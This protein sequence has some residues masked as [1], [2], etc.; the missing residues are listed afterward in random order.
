[1]R[2]VRCLLALTLSWLVGSCGGEVARSTS[3]P[4]KI[5][6]TTAA[7]SS[8]LREGTDSA[9]QSFGVGMTGLPISWQA[10]ADVTWLRLTPASG[11]A[12]STVSVT[13]KSAGLAAGNHIGVIT[14]TPTDGSTTSETVTVLLS[15]VA[16]SVI[17]INPTALTFTAVANQPAVVTQTVLVTHSRAGDVAWSVTPSAS[18]LMATPTS[19]IGDAAVSVG[20]DARTLAAGT[21]RE[22]LTLSSPTS[23]N[24]PISIPITL[25][26]SQPTAVIQVSASPSNGGTVTGA[27]TFAIGSTASLVATPGAGFVF[28]NW[29]EG[30]TVVG[31]S[32]TYSFAVTA[33]RS[34]VANFAPVQSSVFTVSVSSNPTVGGSTTGAGQYSSGITAT[35]RA[36]PTS[37]YSFV[38]WTENG[39]IVSS[40]AIYNFTVNGNRALV[41]NF[42][43]SSPST[44][45]VTTASSPAAGGTTTGGGQ[46]ASGATVVLTATPAS[47]YRFV[48]WTENGVLI[49]DTP[50][51]TFAAS[52]NRALVANFIPTTATTF[53][54]TTSS[55]PSAGGTTTGGGPSVPAGSSVTVS[56]TAN[57]GYTFASWTENGTVVS[58]SSSYTF[59]ATA[60]RALL[61]NF[62]ANTTP[63]ITVNLIQPSPFT[64]SGDQL[65]I[66][67]TVQSMFQ[68]ATVRA[69]IGSLQTTL[70]N[71]TASGWLGSLDISSLPRGTVQITVTATDINGATASAT[72]NFV[73]DRLPVLTVS[74]PV[75]LDVARPS[76]AYSATCTDDDPNGCTSLTLKLG[77]TNLAPTLASGTSSIS[78][79][80]SLAS[81]N[82]TIV[83]L[84]FTATDSRARTVT[85]TRTIYVESSMQIASVGAAGGLVIDTRSGR[86][87]YQRP[88]NG[89]PPLAIRTFS[90]GADEIITTPPSFQVG[91]AWVTPL[92]AI[93]SF[94][95]TLYEWRN[96]TLTSTA[97]D[98]LYEVRGNYATFGVGFPDATLY[99][100]DLITGGDITVAT[101]TANGNN[102]V[103]ENGDV[104]FWR[105]SD[106]DVYWYHA[107][108]VVRLTNDSDALLWNSYPM[109]DGVN[110][111][112]RK[113][114]P[115]CTGQQYQITLHNGTAETVLAP[116]RAGD[117]RPG[118]AYDVN[119]GWTAFTRPD[120]N[121]IMQAWMRSPAGAIVQVSQFG[122]AATLDALGS[123]GTVVFTSGTRRY[124]AAAG[125]APRDVGSTLG[126]VVWR[127]GQF[128][129]LLGRTVWRIQP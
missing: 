97:A 118:R 13:I 4:S 123:D 122:S 26:V 100:R 43:V 115:C 117:P 10:S 70:T 50:T 101:Q 2:A 46:F 128:Y 8:T 72:G 91:R 87:L 16:R 28:S 119:N 31:T 23:A 102:Y 126:R 75:D 12:P 14:V 104:S 29:T 55:L 110:V 73:H 94:D 41:A 107:G 20:V 92:G 60:N 95:R 86:A 88:A 79:L 103:A 121:N 32:A 11:T 40:A 30:G 9:S 36:T 5:T 68:V 89:G 1:V 38:N 35:V 129:L 108:S 21:Y 93:M 116:M 81:S 44:F 84:L 39:V 99:R 51:Y 17:S 52:S 25:V 127:D 6:L 125:G 98:E 61:A 77:T 48:N 33:N 120:V 62:T 96:G 105:N 34:L 37:G 54:I 24:S 64:V 18:W 56:A 83:T 42:A 76:I 57:A 113:H 112:Y 63:T 111:V 66:Q 109:T 67:A 90:N 45:T 85:A 114:T 71:S 82:G 80:A 53:T 59:T 78:G 124:M 7:L 3:P 58:T 49:A 27:G 15:V 65:S 69:T 47:G 19:G 22:T 106:Y 74:A